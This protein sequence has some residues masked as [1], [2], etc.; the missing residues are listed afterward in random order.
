MKK[1]LIGF[2]LGAIIFASIGV[3]AGTRIS[4]DQI[5]YKET[6]VEDAINTLYTTQDTTVTD[7]ETKLNKYKTFAFTHCVSK[8]GAQGV[9]YFT[10]II[11]NYKYIEFYSVSGNTSPTVKLYTTGMTSS[12]NM[13]KGTKYLTAG[14]ER[15]VITVPSS[16]TA[17]TCV[18]F[19][20]SN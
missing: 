13:A 16:G 17:S 12:V 5:E 1:Y 7:L 15:V 6:T 3:Y 19:M 20:L 8:A 14:N 18:S 4:A 2:G 10:P 11:S 9:F